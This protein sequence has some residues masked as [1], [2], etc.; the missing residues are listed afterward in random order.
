MN[1]LKLAWKFV[2]FY[3]LNPQTLRR[4]SWQYGLQECGGF[5][6]TPVPR[7]ITQGS[8]DLIRVVA[9][10]RDPR[11]RHCLA[12]QA[13]LTHQ[14]FALRTQGIRARVRGWLIEIEGGKV[15]ATRPLPAAR[16]RVSHFQSR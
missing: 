13:L 6:L 14:M 8:N 3:G 16:P 11:V 2:T 15:S 5:T 9:K 4:L 1:S 7:S 10:E 12:H